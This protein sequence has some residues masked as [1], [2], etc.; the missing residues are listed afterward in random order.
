MRQI[1][2]C[3]WRFFNPILLRVVTAGGRRLRHAFPRWGYLGLLILVLMVALVTASN[4]AEARSRCRIT[5]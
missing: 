2:F 4:S 3:G 1:G 5:G